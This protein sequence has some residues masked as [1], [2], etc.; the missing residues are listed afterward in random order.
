MGLS[1]CYQHMSGVSKE[2]SSRDSF[3]IAFAH[4][5]IDK[6]TPIVT[7]DGATDRGVKSSD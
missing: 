3:D 6:K 2:I 4:T 1:F 7:K 5:L